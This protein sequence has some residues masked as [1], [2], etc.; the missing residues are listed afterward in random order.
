MFTKG[1]KLEVYKVD[2]YVFE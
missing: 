1:I 2:F